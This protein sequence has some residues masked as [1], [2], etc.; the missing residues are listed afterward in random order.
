MRHSSA[1]KCAVTARSTSVAAAVRASLPWV[2]GAMAMTLPVA[3]VHA[4]D[5]TNTKKTGKPDELKEIVVSG[6]RQSLQSAQDI[7]KNSDEIVDSI[8]AE[9]ISA[10]PD[11]SVTEALQRVPGVSIN[12][13]AAGRDP[14]HFSVEGSGVVVRGLT[15]VR[16]EIN[17]RDAFTANNGRGLSFADIPAELLV[18][19]DVYKTP[20]A[21]R[22]EG[23]IAGS[24]NLRTRKPFDSDKNLLAFSAEANYGDFVKDW[25]PTGSALA[26]Y[27]WDTSAGEF[28]VLASGVYSEVL[29][30]AD[31]YQISN[32]ATRT[33]FS[34]GDVVP[35]GGTTTVGDVL[36]PRGAVLGT[37]NFD[38]ERYGA[39]GAF[40]WRSPDR[41]M[42]ATVQFLRSDAREAWTE[43]TMEIATDNVTSNG[44]S[45]RV[46]GTTLTFDS[47]G[48]FESGVITGPQAGETDQQ[49]PDPRT[50]INALQSNI[51]RRDHWE[52]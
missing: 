9:D 20:S 30:R 7:K 18:G 22:V 6:V 38:R 25:S 44:D 29:S 16:S 19:V 41:S 14:D 4:A 51:I 13:F 34:D 33:L 31:R 1:A 15:Y 5:S 28:G 36:F 24:V 50:P 47:T 37:Q 11:R 35:N 42:E 32:F 17:G 52:R 49:R 12:R 27:R 40:Q 8:T 48:L 39:S 43:H 26:S 2:A 10:L 46:P 23:G 21:S 3:M 45:R